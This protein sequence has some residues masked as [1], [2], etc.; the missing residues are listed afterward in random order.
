MAY[1]L[2]GH[3]VSNFPSTKRASVNKLFTENTVTRMINRLID[4]DGYVITNGIDWSDFTQDIPVAAWVNQDFEFV[5]HGYY[6][7]ISKDE[8]QSGLQYL[9]SQT[10]FPTDD[11]Q[12]TLYARIIIDKEDSNFPELWGQDDELNNYQAIKFYIDDEERTIPDGLIVNYDVYEVPLV[13]RLQKDNGEW[14][15]VIPLDV[16]FK[17]TS[18]SIQNIDGGEICL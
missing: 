12:H 6:F 18:L 15:T 3:R 1:I 8:S 14:I 13:R 2:D 16:L 9:L 7:A 4:K 11:A 17:F 10:H 5:I